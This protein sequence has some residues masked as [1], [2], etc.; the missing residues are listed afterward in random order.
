MVFLSVHFYLDLSYRYNQ[1]VVGSY[2]GPTFHLDRTQ[3]SSPIT[4]LQGD[5]SST[6]KALGVIE[7]RNLLKPTIR[8][9]PLRRLGSLLF[10]DLY[11]PYRLQVPRHPNCY[12]KVTAT[13]YRE[14]TKRSGGLGT[15]SITRQ[16]RPS[17][18]LAS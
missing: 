17:E 1:V 13:S 8:L 3:P 12:K 15:G 11:T 14:K 10:M 18:T 6:S 16:A 7:T 4:S 9:H 5:E 2:T